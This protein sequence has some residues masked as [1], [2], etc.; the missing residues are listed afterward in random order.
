VHKGVDKSTNSLCADA[1]G[2]HTDI[3]RQHSL[4]I[5]LS[6]ICILK[7]YLFAKEVI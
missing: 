1:I 4:F 3:Y 7:I 6:D 5:K 2:Q